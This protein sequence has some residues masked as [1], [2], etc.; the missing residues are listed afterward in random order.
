MN[1][2]TF[3]EKYYWPSKAHLAPSTLA[4][5]RSDWEN[6]VL[7]RWGAVELC[8]IKAVDI[9]V[10]LSGMTHGQASNALGCLRRMMRKAEAWDMVVVDPTRKS[11]EL[12]RRR[13]P[14][15]PPVLEPGDV[16]VLLR[17]FWGHELEAYVTISVLCGLRRCEAAALYWSDVNLRDGSVRI[18][19]GLQCVGGELVEW[20]T[21]T[22][23]SVRT[24]YLPPE[25]VRRLREVK[26]KGPL[27]PDESGGRMNP[28][29]IARMYRS[30]CK[31]EGLPYVPLTNL[32]HTYARMALEAG[33]QEAEVRSAMGHSERSQMLEQHYFVSDKKIGKNGARKIERLLKS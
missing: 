31:H 22:S 14:Y 24:V 2:A 3:A 7:P 25:A 18:D 8:D 1:L 5:Y 9:E 19:K 6:H 11:I 17:G 33:I 26:G 32:R 21:K 4:G 20:Y 29:R 30:H 12:P 13:D 16:P 23:H 15:V 28:D 27:V 10:W